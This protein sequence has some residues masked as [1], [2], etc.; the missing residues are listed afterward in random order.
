MYPNLKEVPCESEG[1]SN[2]PQFQ[3]ILWKREIVRQSERE[4]E[5]VYPHI[6]IT[7]FRGKAD[8]NGTHLI[9]DIPI[10][11]LNIT[12][13]RKTWENGQLILIWMGKK[14]IKNG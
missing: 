3:D 4:S 13:N 12:D 2:V 8:K 7:A 10:Y 9:T 14:A 11:L 1:I 6:Q 5:K